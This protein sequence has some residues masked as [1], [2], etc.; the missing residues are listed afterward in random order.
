MAAE[1]LH[2]EYGDKSLWISAAGYGMATLVGVSRVYRNRH[3][4][5]DVVAGAGVGILSTKIIYWLYPSIKK[6]FSKKGAKRQ[7]FI[8]PGYN[9]GS[10]G[11]SFSCVF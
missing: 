4:V 1:F 11:I 7:T 8:C 3:W 9:N 6:P 2:Q 10:L 5:S